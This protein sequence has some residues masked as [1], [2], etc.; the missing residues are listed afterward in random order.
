RFRNPAT[1]LRILAYT[2]YHPGLIQHFCRELLKH[3]R[4]RRDPEPP[5]MI[6]HTDVE[7]VYRK[8]EVRDMIRQRFEL[9]IRLDP[10]YEAISLAVAVEQLGSLDGFGS[11][12]RADEIR[13]LVRSYWPQGFRQ[14]GGDAFR[15][16]L[17]EMCGL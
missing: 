5:F 8:F 14:L 15:G 16:L 7:A 12:Y 17:R 11:A 4:Q 9:T 10:R 3:L 13:T 2:N 6:D 1:I